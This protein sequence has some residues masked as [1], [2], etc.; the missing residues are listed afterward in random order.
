MF[1]GGY[2]AVLMRYSQYLRELAQK[3]HLQDADLNTSVVAALR[4]AKEKDPVNAGKLLPDRVHPAAAGHL[5]MAEAL[6]RAWNA[7][8]LV[9]S[10]TID[11]VEGKTGDGQNVTVTNLKT[12]GSLSWDAL[13]S[14]LPMALDPK[15]KLLP[16]AIASSD[17]IAA[18]DREELKVSG[19][20][21]GRYTL[22]IDGGTVGTYGAEELGQG[23]NLATADTPMLHQ[24]LDVH[25][26][27]LQHTN[28]H[29]IR[30]RTVQVPMA[31]DGY[32]SKD[33]VMADLD[34]L[35]SEI[36]AQQRAVAQPK[37]HHFELAS[38]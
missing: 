1:A 37:T 19:L 2:N 7:P 36:I 6:L 14:A 13:E 3:E 15:D 30:W 22:K 28:I 33:K 29:N 34:R 17:F 21:A 5:L 26:L 23:I 35:D 16:L 10:V 12:D 32:A 8:S 4:V 18:L 24:A 27:T 9:S 11:A 20:K 38:Q 31:K 25:A